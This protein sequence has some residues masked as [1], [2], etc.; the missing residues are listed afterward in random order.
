[1]PNQIPETRF[2]VKQKRTALFAKQRET[3]QASAL[4]NYVTTLENLMRVF[5]SGSKVGSD[6]IKV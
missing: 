2:W 1:M 5:N 4:K 3:Y 6:K